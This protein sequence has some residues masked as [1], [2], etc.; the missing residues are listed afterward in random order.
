MPRHISEQYDNELSTLR[1]SFTTMAGLV[2][3]QLRRAMQAFMNNDS[4][5]ANEVHDVERRINEY[6]I[7]LDRETTSVI[8]RR[9]PAATDL[10]LLVSIFK[11]ITDLERIGDEANRIAKLAERLGAYDQSTSV[12]QYLTRLYD[13]TAYNLGSSLDAY[14]RLDVDLAVKSISEDRNV[15]TLYDDTVN[16]VTEQISNGNIRI[17]DGLPVIW[18][19]RSLE[20]IGDHGKNIS[21]NV[22]YLVNGDTLRH[23]AT[24]QQKNIDVDRSRSH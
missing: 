5:L 17:E 20:R 2:E 10:R 24:S 4:Q 13:A 1:A 18:V 21:E 9:H 22:Y 8:A 6:E 23:S 14:A 15:D 11:N 3:Q 16:A 12:H 7:E 19:A